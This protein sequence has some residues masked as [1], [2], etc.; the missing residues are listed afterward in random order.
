MSALSPRR[1]SALRAAVT[2]AALASAVLTPAAA[3]FAD[4]PAAPAAPAAP[5]TKAVEAAAGTTAVTT[6]AA[7]APADKGQKSGQSA[8]EPSP[9]KEGKKT[10]EKPE[11]GS[12]PGGVEK[13]EP[14]S[15][16]GSVV[17]TWAPHR[18]V[19]LSDGT[20]IEVFESGPETHR[21]D[22]MSGGTVVKSVKA[23]GRDVSFEYH[24]MHLTLTAQRGEILTKPVDG[25]GVAGKYIGMTRLPQA[26]VVRVY[27]L[28]PNHYRGLVA[29]D[30]AAGVYRESI[31]A[32]GKDGYGIYNHQR[33][34]VSSADGTVT[35][36]V[37][38]APQNDG[39]CIV[40]REVNI[41]AG[42][43]A[44]LSNGPKGPQVSYK[45]GYDELSGIIMDRQHPSDGRTGHIIDPFGAHPKLW[46]KMQGGDY[47]SVTSDFPDALPGCGA[48]HSEPVGTGST[49]TGAAKATNASV[50]LASSDAAQTKAIPEGG[51]AAGAE[52]VREGND[53]ALAAA[54]GGFAAVSAAGIA[55][56]VLRRRAVGVRG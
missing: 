26:G 54:V 52:G 51:V 27:K 4:A 6:P 20:V 25:D 45:T 53:A 39:G 44:V 5:V 8:A 50:Q 28:G 13:D 19:T 56:T 2:T 3:A 23:D 42:T 48:G 24:G 35:A 38:S 29:R 33:I 47:P 17:G 14:V 41:G 22:V 16:K 12:K 7:P 43:I 30:G 21:A 49:G 1:R 15:G 34:K 10:E 36:E 32:D 55:F 11:D 9:S 46:T 37:L 31:E 40:S 18:T